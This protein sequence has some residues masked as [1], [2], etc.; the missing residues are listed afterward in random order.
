MK[1]R[2]NW[3]DARLE[4][5]PPAK[6]RAPGKNQIK[7]TNIVALEPTT[8]TETLYEFELGSTEVLGFGLYSGFMVDGQF[9]TQATANDA[10]TVCGADEATKVTVQP[11]WFE[12]MVKQIDVFHIN[13][14][15]NPHD[16]PVTADAFLNSYLL[17]Y[18][19]HFTKMF[20]C[21]EPCN[22][23]NAV[24][25]EKEG[26]RATA[27]SDYAKYAKH[28]F[29]KEVKFRYIPL[30]K[31]PFYQSPN[32]VL[33][34]KKPTALPMS[35][36]GSLHIRL[37]LK[38]DC[39]KIFK[40]I[41]GNNANYRF[42]IKSIQL[43]VEEMRMGP[44]AEKQF[45]NQRRQ[46]EFAGVTK[47]G[48]AHNIPTGI[49]TYT[50]K[51]NKLYQPEGIFIC[52]LP[53]SVVPGTYDFKDY[54][55]QV[56]LEHRIKSVDVYFGGKPF[57]SKK[58]TPYDLGAGLS[59]EKIF[60][61]HL[62]APPFGVFQKPSLLDYAKMQN[63]SKLSAYPHVYID[64]TQGRPDSRIIPTNDP[65]TIVQNKD[66]LEVVMQFDTQGP[67]TNGTYF[68]YYFYTDS[69]IVFDPHAKRFLNVYNNTKITS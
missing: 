51:I 26:W 7:G 9:E 39:T 48:M 35:L 13:A 37:Y 60:F 52:C 46:L 65:G 16:V 28:I 68:V 69:N 50:A 6:W 30:F 53:K 1:R 33:D 20:L 61:D 19:D 12:H 21:P 40:K 54:V 24:T 25:V 63:G 56:F 17:A 45:T 2:E 23:G 49:F 15:I 11:N 57:Y 31:F 4:S 18:M 5:H 47:L 44:T 27:T 34:G 41:D 36:I 66:F 32:F 22:P 8:K 62:I 58:P 55:D 3:N 64:L 43:M 67:N 42:K 29:G 14:E 38:D 10:W 59:D